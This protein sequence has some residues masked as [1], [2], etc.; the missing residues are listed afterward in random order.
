FGMRPADVSRCRVLEL[1]CGDGLH[2]IAVAL[3]LPE[4]ECVGI[5]LATAGLRKGQAI[6]RELGLT[7][8]TLRH[9]DL[10]EVGQEL[11]QFDFIIAHGIYSWVPPEARDKL[12]A[13]CKENLT[14]NGVAYVSY[15]AYPGSHFRDIVREMMRYHVREC[16]DPQQRVEQA[17]ELIR[18][19]V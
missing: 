11:G 16:P 10:R 9:M 13:I 6:I 12:L 14:A 8:V 1:G 7:N 5:D 15:N 17:R 4:A 19:L 18:F 2:L 3:G